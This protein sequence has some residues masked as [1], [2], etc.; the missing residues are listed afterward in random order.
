MNK[1]LFSKFACY[2][3]VVSSEPIEQA[4]PEYVPDTSELMNI[5]NEIF[6]V[7]ERTG[8]PLGDLSYFLSPNGNPTVKAW[9]ENNLLKPRFGEKMHNPDITDDMLIEFSRGADESVDSYA[10]RLADLR[11]QAFDE[12][13]KSLNPEK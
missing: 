3:G 9:L 8:Q 13:N 4:E 2:A 1:D 10:A 5:L 6:S 11:Q 12:Y 7:D